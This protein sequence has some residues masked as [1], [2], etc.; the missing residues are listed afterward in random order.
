MTHECQ[1]HRENSF[2]TLTYSPKHLPENQT[3][4]LK[5]I[6]DFIKRLRR[7]TGK[8]IRYYHCGEYGSKQG[9]PHYHLVLFGHD[10][11]DKYEFMRRGTYPVHR[12]PLLES[13][14]PFGFSEIGTVTWE[15]ISYVAR[16]VTKK[17]DDAT[18]S[19]VN[20][21]EIRLPEYSTM[22]RRPAIGRAWFEKWWLD[23]YPSDFIVIN[24][25]KMS[26]PKYYDILLE[27]HAPDM[28]AHVRNIRIAKRDREN[29]TPA[30]MAIR[31]QVH[32]ARNALSN[33][34][35]ESI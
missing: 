6:Q 4:V 23:V 17:M 30:R 31:K 12:S 1:M 14:W 2:I 29:Q 25:K 20:S 33:A 11:S 9:R 21:G 7:R 19:D 24:G 34:R 13:L 26:P 27:K 18:R 10:F 8:N 5:H 28:W 32:D 22:S 16:Y 3:L 35:H 15:S